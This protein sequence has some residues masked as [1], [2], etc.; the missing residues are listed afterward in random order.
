MQQQQAYPSM[1][2]ELLISLFFPHEFWCNPFF[3]IPSTSASTEKYMP[4][5]Q[6]LNPLDALGSLVDLED[7]KAMGKLAKK[8]ILTKAFNA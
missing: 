8:F 5:V 1:S 7:N 6:T 2:V 3:S 4:L